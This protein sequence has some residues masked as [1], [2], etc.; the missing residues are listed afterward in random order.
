MNWSTHVES[1]IKKANKAL[2]AI[3]IIRKFFRTNELINIVTSNFY[4]ILFYNSEIWHLPTLDRNLRHSLF[5]ASANALK[6]CHHYSNELISYYNYHKMS[7][8]ATP[9]MMC[10]YKLALSLYKTMNNQFPE[11][12][13]THLNFNQILTSRQSM[14]ATKRAD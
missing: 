8:R 4:S 3:K 5:T 11:T 7:D 6:I 14:F 1:C 2:N 13:W 9:E 10:N 12:E